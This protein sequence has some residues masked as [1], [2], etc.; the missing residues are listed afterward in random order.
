M[1]C[2]NIWRNYMNNKILALI[3]LITMLLLVGCNKAGTTEQPTDNNQSESN[4]E[5]TAPQSVEEKNENGE[6]F[7]KAKITSLDERNYIHVEVFDSEVAFGPYR[8][9]VGEVT[10]YFDKD[11]NSISITDLKVGDSIEIIFNGQVMTSNPPQI[12]AL[13]IH[14]I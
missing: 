10:K 2:A 9:I 7:F 5:S 13:R 4:N 8:V 11:G 1:S 3:L 6:F 14:L 12:A